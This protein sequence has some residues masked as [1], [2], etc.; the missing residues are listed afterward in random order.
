VGRLG[1]VATGP[2]AITTAVVGMVIGECVAAFGNTVQMSVA[3]PG[4]SNPGGGGSS[5]P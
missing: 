2:P 3:N 1:A 5:D 4:S